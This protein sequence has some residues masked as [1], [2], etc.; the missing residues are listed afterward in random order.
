MLLLN[1]TKLLIL[2]FTKSIWKIGICIVVLLLGVITFASYSTFY[3]TDSIPDVFNYLFIKTSFFTLTIPLFLFF[4]S[5][6]LPFMMD[7]L[8]LTRFKE[9]KKLGATILFTVCLVT[10]VFLAV[11]FIIGFL[12]GWWKSGSLS[13]P[14]VTEEGTPFILS[15]GKVDLSLFKTGYMFL[16]YTITE[17][18]AF[19]VIGLLASFLY[20]LIPRYILVF[21]IVE[22]FLILDITIQSVLNFTIFITQAEVSLNNWGNVTYFIG[23]LIYFSGL[24]VVLI[25]GIHMAS[26][27]RDFIPSVEE[28]E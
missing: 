10:I 5:F 12:Y 4:L 9:R 15:K 18:F 7:P 1:Y 8:R 27:K 11:Y 17:F 22:G 2:D 3:G 24:I 14:W 25:I 6:F 20:L 23:N 13:N 28:T 26:R 19:M 16:R 21:F